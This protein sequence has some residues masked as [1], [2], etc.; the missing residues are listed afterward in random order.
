MD[1]KYL[2][3]GFFFGVLLFLLYIFLQILR[4]F[5]FVIFW[6]AT[7]AIVFYPLQDRFERWFRG[8]KT[9]AAGVVTFLI[10]LALLIP[11]TLVATTLGA[12]LVRAFEGAKGYLSAENINRRVADFLSLFPHSWF[13]IAKDKLGWETLSEP[14]T[15]EAILER[16][17]SGFIS[18]IPLGAKGFLVG[19]IYLAILVITLFFFLRDGPAMVFNLKAV[20]PMSQDQKDRIFRTF[21][22]ILH[23]VIA[24]VLITAAVQAGLMALL[25]VVLGI[26]F[27]ILG[28]VVTFIGGTLPIGGASLVWVPGSIILFLTGHVWKGAVLL[29]VG[30]LVV[31]SIDNIVKPMII[32]SRARIPTL[33]LFFSI[34]GGLKLF[35]FT[36]ILL[37][38]VILAVF[39]SLLDIYKREYQGLADASKTPPGA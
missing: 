18:L 37:G 29:G 11:L 31:S 2:V 17:A 15:V 36:G 3:A 27:P 22:E 1:R 12:E 39:L 25:L 32:G 30:A 20:I 19:L 24:G 35:G 34:L 10:L 26:P 4:P 21:Y 7:L 13:E 28:G 33:L 14:E 16:V 23:S 38:P 5:Y 8:R 9:A 6:A